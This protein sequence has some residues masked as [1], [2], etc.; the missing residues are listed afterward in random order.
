ML[1]FFYQKLEETNIKELPPK[2][3]YCLS[4]LFRYNA[5]NT[6]DLILEYVFLNRASNA[7]IK[8]KIF[9]EFEYCNIFQ[10]LYFKQ[11]AKKK[12]KEKNKDENFKKIK[13]AKGAINIEGYGEDGTICPI[14]LE[15]KKSI[16]ALPCKHFFCSVCMDK[17]LDEGNCPICRTKIKITFDINLKKEN[18]I[19]SKL[20]KPKSS[21]VYND[22]FNDPELD[23]F[24]DP[25]L[26]Y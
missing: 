10:E 20:V 14:C 9:K 24:F 7:I 6:K 3:F 4:Q 11:K 15:N 26:D 18:L 12:I 23:P 21:F 19:K 1:N 16:I 17:L 2:F 22:P 5:I 8:D 25:E 13:E